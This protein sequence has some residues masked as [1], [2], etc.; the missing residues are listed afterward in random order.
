MVKVLLLPY[1]FGCLFFLPRLIAEARTSSTLLNNS[2]ESKHPC[3]VPGHRG[4]SVSF[5]P[6]G[7]FKPFNYSYQSSESIMLVV[8]ND[9]I[10]DFVIYRI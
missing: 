6:G 4:I 1:Q 5:S 9:M 3:R 2:S 10:S 8:G 7:Q